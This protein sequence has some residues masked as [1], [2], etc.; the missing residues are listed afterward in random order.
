MISIDYNDNTYSA[1]ISSK[2]MDD[3]WI[4][5]TNFC[6]QE[7]KE[8]LKTSLLSLEIPWWSFLNIKND[9]YFM[10]KSNKISI[11]I[12]KAVEDLL[13]S[14]R[15]EITNLNSQQMEYTEEE[16]NIRLSQSGFIRTL[17][18]FQT[19]N[20]IKL[21]RYPSG[22]TFS[23][24][25][26]G[27]T[28]EALAF[29]G[30]YKT[31]NS[32]LLVVLPKNAFIAWEEQIPECFSSCLSVM[33]LTGGYD[34]IK[35]ILYTEP[36]VLLITYQQLVN[37][38]DLV[39]SYLS[40][41]DSFIFVDES[42][43]MKKG[44][45]GR[46]ASVILKLSVV[47]KYK[48]VM[49]GTPMP[50]DITDLIP[51]FNFLYPGIKTSEDNI[52]NN[53]SKIY[54]RTTKKD[55]DLP[56]PHFIQT[57]IEM[58]TTQQY[59]YDIVTDDGRRSVE[60]YLKSR[61]KNTLRSIKKSCMLMIQLISN[62]A[63]LISK[64]SNETLMNIMSIGESPKINYVCKKAR[65]L[66]RNNRKVLIWTNFVENVE[67][68]ANR[69][70]DLNAVY[71]HGGIPSGCKEDCNTREY[72][73]DKFIN[74]DDCYVMVANPAAACEGISL[75]TKCYYA[76]YV[77]RTFNAAHYLQSLDRIHRLGSTEEVTIE[78]LTTIQTIDDAVD[79]RLFQKTQ[80]MAT[81][82]NDP[83]IIREYEYSDEENDDED[84]LLG[85]KDDEMDYILSKIWGGR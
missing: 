15:N 77:D 43:R 37:V 23:V 1:I 81:V 30:F 60:A 46:A 58:S 45:N 55:L 13:I 68:I 12:T 11:S 10:V 54:V 21:V 47:P 32:K 17:K 20:L 75:H 64:L 19:R 76:I 14:S 9:I 31:N 34:N 85:L 6:F 16:I 28:T 74:D 70:Q 84:D 62:P 3:C 66:A 18:P 79:E 63:L 24:P 57:S 80:N 22:A 51:Q 59:L 35:S 78:I 48:L 27:K 40:R 38:Y 26:A 2:F 72:R 61:D 73:I 49:S 53:I 65:L 67:I 56:M 4:K 82:L 33:R 39:G 7:S 5:I 25:G 42:H 8:T 29:Y 36:D 50:Q 41:F 83:S 52:V 69:L 71:I 44:V